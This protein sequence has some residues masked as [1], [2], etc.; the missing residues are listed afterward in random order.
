MS[1]YTKMTPKE[2]LEVVRE[3]IDAPD[4][5]RLRLTM[6]ANEMMWKWGYELTSGAVAD[7]P[8]I[9]G[10][11]DWFGDLPWDYCIG[12]AKRECVEIETR[13]SSRYWELP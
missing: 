10:V 3:S 4:A 1:K 11:P 13:A 7:T 9:D 2:Y 8:N 5:D 6:D 12:D